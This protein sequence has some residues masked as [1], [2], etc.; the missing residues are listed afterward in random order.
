MTNGIAQP[1][2]S[3][4][5]SYPTASLRELFTL[6][7]PLIL[8]F[9]STS[10]MSFCS[11]LFLSNFSMEALQGCTCAIY[12]CGLFQVPCMRLTSTAQVFVGLYKGANSPLRIGPCIW[13]MVWFSLLSMV[14]TL[15]LGLWLAPSFF[16]GTPIK[17]S[18]LEYF[19]VLLYFN[20]LFP[21]GTAL[22]CFYIGR[23]KM[24]II[25]LTTL[26]IHGINIFLD[27]LLIFGIQGVI[28][29]LGALG[30]AISMVVA[31]T[32]F[33][34]ILLLLFLRKQ[35]RSQFGTANYKFQ[36]NSFWE[37]TRVGLPR[38]IVR[39]VIL[40][41]WAGIVHLMTLE[42]GDYL[43]VLSIGGTLLLLF[44][45]INDGMCQGLITIASTLM[46]SKNYAS[47]WRLVRSSALFLGITTLLLTI[48]YL[49]FP[50]ITLSFFSLG[51]INENSLALLKR[52]F[53]WLWIFFFCY[54]FNAIGLSLIT[55]SR[56]VTFYLIVTSFVWLTS[57]VPAYYAIKV[58]K[59]S[60]D[61]IWLIMAFDSFIFGVIFLL[62][63]L[64]EKWKN[65]NIASADKLINS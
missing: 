25:F 28:P 48:P 12:L 64:K 55:A 57:Y 19:N 33:C 5:T 37:Y 63:S 53:L 54:G 27:Y 1:P 62:R 45:F 22:S 46:G 20:F 43:L 7:F 15:P 17:S 42:G 2:D 8:S 13:Q 36:W 34:L 61:I 56:D 58:W 32:L 50:D 41:S 29:P 30:A 24:K 35:E 3:R 39:I 11:R 38:A 65:S 47:I 59:L 4:L 40:A 18:G 60:P 6:S 26:I 9:F 31:Q 16:D 10:F 44:S 23:G 52:A 21:L 14:V 51:V 49:M